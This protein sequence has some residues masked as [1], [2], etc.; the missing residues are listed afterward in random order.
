MIEPSFAT[1]PLRTQAGIV[2]PYGFHV[3][4]GPMY[5]KIYYSLQ[6]EL[7]AIEPFTPPDVITLET[8]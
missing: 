6:G 7:W 2:V 3:S 4:T 8:Q 5:F 1:Y